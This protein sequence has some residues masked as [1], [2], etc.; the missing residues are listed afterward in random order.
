VFDYKIFPEGHSW[1]LWRANTGKTLSYLFPYPTSVE[2]V[3]LLPKRFAINSYP[4]PFNP[5]ITISVELLEKSEISL[6]VFSISG[7]K[8]LNVYDGELTA[9]KHSF[10]TSF[11]HLSTGVYFAIA[12]VNGTIV[13]HKM[14]LIK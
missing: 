6:S 5:S 7:E 14:L 4:N 1:G 2:N 11:S 8:I 10:N 12:Q 3:T 9:G 13:S